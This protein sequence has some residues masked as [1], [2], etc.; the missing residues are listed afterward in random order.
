V[1]DQGFIEGKLHENTTDW[2]AQDKRGNVWYFGEATEELGPKGEVESTE[3]SWQAG[4]PVGRHGPKAMAGIFM[5][6]TPE[7]GVGFKQEVA[8]GISEDEFETLD[9]NASVSTP[10]V[11]TNRVLRTK[12]FSPQEPGVTDN[13]YYVLGIGTVI[14]NTPVGP[15]DTLELVSLT[16]P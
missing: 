6:D 15:E 7:V 10:Y 13:K 1:H 4:R 8:P 12:E 16:R 11:T 3:G 9:L 2:Y 14:E 5:P